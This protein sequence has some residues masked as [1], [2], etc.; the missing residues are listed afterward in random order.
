MTKTLSPAQNIKIRKPK[1]KVSLFE[2]LMAILATANLCLVFF[3]MTY[4]PMRGF[5]FSLPS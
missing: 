4:V 1:R 2:R 5:V 3:N